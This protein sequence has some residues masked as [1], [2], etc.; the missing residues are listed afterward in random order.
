[1]M[2]KLRLTFYMAK[3]Y[4]TDLRQKAIEAVLGG[5]TLVE[6]SQVPKS[7]ILLYN[8]GSSKGLKRVIVY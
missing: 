8:A 7:D 2:V 6:V 4:S 3:L 1:M 5:V